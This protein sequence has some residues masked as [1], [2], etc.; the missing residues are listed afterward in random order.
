MR[1]AN[2]ANAANWRPLGERCGEADRH[3][4]FSSDVTAGRWQL[5][6]RRGEEEG[7]RGGGWSFYRGLKGMWQ[8]MT[9]AGWQMQAGGVGVNRSEREREGGRQGRRD[10]GSFK[11]FISSQRHRGGD[12]VTPT[13]GGRRGRERG[14]QAATKTQ[15]RFH[16]FHFLFPVGFWE[17]WQLLIQNICSR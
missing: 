11:C 4:D 16:F 1:A 14:R 3:F 7:V 5:T 15:Q 9:E 8:Q 13:Q 12:G 10:Q 2:A 17:V 6:G